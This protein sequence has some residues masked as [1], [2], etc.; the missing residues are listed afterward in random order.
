M[1]QSTG[2]PTFVTGK[3]IKE[4]PGIC[5]ILENGYNKW[6]E[7]LQKDYNEEKIT[8]EVFDK[9]MKQIDGYKKDQVYAIKPK[10]WHANYPSYDNL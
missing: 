4:Y 7:E 10:D 6:A 5:N 9:N 3:E 8:K 2:R 1:D